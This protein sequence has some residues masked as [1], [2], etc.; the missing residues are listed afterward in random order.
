MAFQP[1]PDRRPDPAPTSPRP[2][3]PEG[4][5][6]GRAR[7]LATANRFSRTGTG[8]TSLC[9]PGSGGCPDGTKA[10]VPAMRLRHLPS[11]L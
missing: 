8:A 1:R 9:P 6:T 11:G 10:P 2:L 3:R 7:Q 4:R 5:S